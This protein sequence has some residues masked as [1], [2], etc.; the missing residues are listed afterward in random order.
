MP[1]LGDSIGS[2]RA[3]GNLLGMLYTEVFQKNVRQPNKPLNRSNHIVEDQPVIENVITFFKD[4]TETYVYGPDFG[5]SSHA[6][7]VAGASSA[8]WG[9]V[10]VWA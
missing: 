8:R 2:E 1:H 5:H 4:S 6:A 10:G 3:L 9:E 7:G